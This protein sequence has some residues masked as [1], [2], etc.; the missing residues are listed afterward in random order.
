MAGLMS[1]LESSFEDQRHWYWG[2]SFK[3][4]A[5]CPSVAGLGTT[6]ADHCHSQSI[7]MEGRTI[8]PPPNFAFG[9]LVRRAP[10]QWGPP[11]YHYS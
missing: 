1:E 6:I 3:K 9:T 7:F 10:Q 5:P 2:E 11:A 4:L 8:I